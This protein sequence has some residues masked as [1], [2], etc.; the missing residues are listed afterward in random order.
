MLPVQAEAQS[1][2][3]H[4]QSPGYMTGLPIPLQ[5]RTTPHHRA[6]VPWELVLVVVGYHHSGCH[7]GLAIIIGVRLLDEVV[8]EELVGAVHDDLHE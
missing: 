2:L 8:V 7:N 4:I 3:P 6:S 5:R 1:I